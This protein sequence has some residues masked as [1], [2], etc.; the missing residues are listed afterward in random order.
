MITQAAPTPENMIAPQP[1]WATDVNPVAIPLIST[2]STPI[3][4]KT[5]HQYPSRSTSKVVIHCPLIDIGIALFSRYEQSHFRLCA[6]GI[7]PAR[8]PIAVLPVVDDG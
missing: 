5:T 7:G 8:F 4:P 1:Y 2:D 6:S 3:G